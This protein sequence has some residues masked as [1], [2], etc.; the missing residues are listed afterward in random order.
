MVQFYYDADEIEYAA[1]PMLVKPYRRTGFYIK[2]KDYNSY[3]TLATVKQ[4]Q[5][6]V[7]KG[8]MMT[9]EEIIALRGSINPDSDNVMHASRKLKHMRKRR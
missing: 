2:D 4:L 5:K 3:D 1:N 6:S 7:D 8:D 9:D